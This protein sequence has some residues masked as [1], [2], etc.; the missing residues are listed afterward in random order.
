MVLRPVAL[1]ATKP[2]WSQWV[3]EVVSAEV[4]VLACGG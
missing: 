2:T 1:L 3:R 4:V